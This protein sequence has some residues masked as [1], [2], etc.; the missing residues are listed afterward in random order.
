MAISSKEI[1]IDS[2]LIIDEYIE[3]LKTVDSKKGH[4]NLA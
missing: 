2:L 3:F 1:C 4:R